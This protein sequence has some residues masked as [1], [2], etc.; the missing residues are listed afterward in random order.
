MKQVL[1]GG[2]ALVEL[3]SDR[4]TKD[5]DF[6]VNDTSTKEMFITGTRIDYLNANG[7]KFFKEIW[8]IEKDNEIASPESLLQLKAYSFVQHCQNFNWAKV[9]STEYDIKF[10]V[11]KFGVT[12]L[13]IVKKYVSEGELSEI[14]KLIDE[15]KNRK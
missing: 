8:N 9:D 6:L 3:G 7:N 13:N 5:V 11:R 15:V 14:Q 1:I 4:A 12:K 2:Q 10:L